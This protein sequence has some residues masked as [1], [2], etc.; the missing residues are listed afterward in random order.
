[1]SHIFHLIT[2]GNIFWVIAM[3]ASI[4]VLLG[5]TAIRLLCGKE[6]FHRWIPS[7]WYPI[8]MVL[9][10]IGAA[11]GQ[12]TLVQWLHGPFLQKGTNVLALISEDGRIKKILPE[13]KKVWKNEGYREVPMTRTFLVLEWM[14]LGS[15]GKIKE[16]RCAVEVKIVDFDAYT[17]TGGR[18]VGTVDSLNRHP[19][20]DDD[21]FY[22]MAVPAITF[23]RWW[24]A[25]HFLGREMLQGDQ[26]QRFVQAAEDTLRDDKL[27]VGRGVAFHV[28]VKLP[29]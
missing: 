12:D 23:L 25:D 20:K 9:S 16:S 7:W 10:L 4:A 22:R 27:Y 3:G 6:T 26:Q 15:E 1:M 28:Q 18:F 14:D 29:E 5:I 13:A 11:V 2:P 8:F 17:A 24:C 19:S 21:S